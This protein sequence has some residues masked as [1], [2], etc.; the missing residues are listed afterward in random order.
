MLFL[1]LAVISS[2]GSVRADSA[3]VKQ[4]IKDFNAG[5]YENAVG[6]LGAA[7]STDF[8][9]ARLHYYLGSS[10]VHLKQSESAT[11]EFRIAYAL[12]PTTE[13]GKFAHKALVALGVETDHSSG[14]AGQPSAVSM[15]VVIP[16]KVP[17]WN[18]PIDYKDPNFMA[19][20]KMA[21]TA[22]K[23]WNMLT[24]TNGADHSDQVPALA[25]TWRPRSKFDDSNLP[26]CSGDGVWFKVPEWLAGSWVPSGTKIESSR[27]EYEKNSMLISQQ[28][29]PRPAHAEIWGMAK[30]SEGGQVWQHAVVPNIIDRHVG[31][32]RVVDVCVKIQP[33]ELS[34]EKVL[35][36]HRGI[37]FVI[38]N[39]VIQTTTQYEAILEYLPVASGY[40][41]LNESVKEFDDL[42]MPLRILKYRGYLKLS[43]P[44]KL[45]RT[46]PN[47]ENYQAM[48]N[49]YLSGH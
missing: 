13:V 1:A 24:P 4:G 5:D 44:L 31:K 45:P 27:Q 41:Q 20:L 2:N 17:A 48:L 34:T 10:Y 23:G 14:G 28:P 30:E 46:G 26:D 22:S 40:C 15:F 7:L 16:P 32:A 9:D 42:G 19:W 3:L 6:H 18:G 25:T 33:V 29:V 11:R 39:D 37:S 36:F 43:Q 47:G 21:Q 49:K 12:E 8:N 38:V 35:L